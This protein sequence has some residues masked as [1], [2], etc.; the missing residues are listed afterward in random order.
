M[1]H[2]I[3]LISRWECLS[4]KGNRVREFYLQAMAQ[5]LQSDSLEAARDLIHSISVVAFSKSEGNNDKGLPVVSETCKAQ[6]KTR[7]A[8]GVLLCVN[9]DDH[10]T[11]VPKLNEALHTDLKA[12][13]TEICE[14]RLQ[15]IMVTETIFISFQKL[16]Q[17]S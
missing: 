16:S 5:L 9:E 3:K 15:H 4:Q 8:E 2:C 1:A 14:N 11:E 7:L 12:W 6:L 17:I 10:S 13:V